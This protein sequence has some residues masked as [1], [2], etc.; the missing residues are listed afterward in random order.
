MLICCEIS[1]KVM[2]Q[3]TVLDVLKIATRGGG[4]Y[5]DVFEKEVLNT[6][7]LTDY[8]NNTY[9][10]NGIAWDKKPSDTFQGRDGPISFI[11]YYQQRYNITIRDANQPLL[12]TRLTARDIRGG[13]TEPAL[14][15]PE[16]CRTTGLTDGMRAN[17]NMMKGLSDY[18]KMGPV[19][20]VKGL[21][22]YSRRITQTPASKDVLELL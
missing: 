17:F 13:R 4:S 19:N 12:W 11:Q 9:S 2:R 6:V 16:L 21:R 18:T 10:V 1:H 15:V 8:N 20:R 7:V 3:E 14:L 22:D 5:K